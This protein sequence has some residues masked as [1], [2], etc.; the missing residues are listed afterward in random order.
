MCHKDLCWAH[1]CTLCTLTIFLSTIKSGEVLLYADD[2]T[3]F[4]IDNSTHE[5]VELINI[6]FEEFNESCN[7]NRLTIHTGKSEVMIIQQQPFIG[8]LL[9]VKFGDNI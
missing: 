3:A 9:P 4:V 1:D 5:M 6:L 7:M 8:P 2:T